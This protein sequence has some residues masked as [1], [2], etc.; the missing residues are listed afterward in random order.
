MIDKAATISEFCFKRKYKIKLLMYNFLSSN[1]RSMIFWFAF[2]MITS[3]TPN[4]QENADSQSNDTQQ[5]SFENPPEWAKEVIW[6]QIY[7]ERFRNGDPTND[8]SPEDM[9]GSYPGFV[10]NNWKITPWTH[11]WYQPDAYFTELAGKKDLAGYEMTYFG[12]LSRLRRYGGDLQGVLD[13]IDYLDSLGV[14]AIYFNPLNDGPSE[15]K[16]D[17]R[18]WRHI[19]RNF[20]PSPRKDVQIMA[21]ETPDDPST[22]QMTGADQMFVEVIKKFHERGIK[23]ILD[24]SWNHT[25]IDFWAWKD[26]LKNQAQS[27]FKDWYWVKQFDDPTTPE[28]EFDYQGWF[29]VKDLA[30]IK[31]TK[32]VDHAK[33]AYLYEGNLASEAAKQHIF[34]V[35]RKWLDPNGDGDPSDGVDG[36]RLDVSPELPMGFWREFRQVVREVNPN[37]YLVGE[38]WFKLYPDSMLDPEP[39]LKGDIFDAVMNYR[40]YKA[41][42]EFFIG[43]NKAI[44]PS[45]FVDSIQRITSNLRPQNNQVMMNIASSHDSPRLLTS[46]FNKNNKYKFQVEPSQTVD[47]LIHK[48]DEEA[49]QT[50]RLILAQQFT[51]IGAPH[52]WAGEEMGMWGADLGDARKPLI[53]PDY[54]FEEERV[55]PIQR[56]RPVDKVQFNSEVFQYYQKL[57][58]IRKDNPVLIHGDIEFIVIDDG[59]EVLAYRRFD[60]DKE[61]IAIFNTSQTE[62]IINIP[63]QNK[64]TYQDVLYG[65]ALRQEAN[66]I[67][68]TLPPRTAAILNQK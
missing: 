26:L 5:T 62:Q 68:I 15:H 33:G 24:Y 56:E 21:Q 1:T 6:Y 45:A 46:V 36:Y 7:P 49:H 37:A 51:Y 12:Q 38:C 47:Y 63:I 25:G 2:L 3:C 52:I 60:D 35:A 10:P 32:Y 54:N 19:D 31:E 30:E 16:Y 13:Q 11:D 55:H 64:G 39:I 8:P 53:W 65:S 34:Q 23:V 22:W 43:T 27:K 48:P 66:D 28:N 17:A 59:Q 18:H 4:P 9:A 61:V 44:K 50:A 29:G 40:W 20:G 57:I 58:Q 42:R 67:N 41:A 14:T